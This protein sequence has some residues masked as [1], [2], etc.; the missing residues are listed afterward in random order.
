[1][2]FKILYHEEDHVL[3]T[4][5][6]QQDYED[7]LANFLSYGSQLS[8]LEKEHFWIETKTMKI[9]EVVETIETEFYLIVY[10]DH[11]QKQWYFYG[12]SMNHRD[13]FA[14][15][16][17]RNGCRIFSLFCGNTLK[18]HENANGDLINEQGEQIAR[19]ATPESE[20]SSNGS[21]DTLLLFDESESDYQ[22]SDSGVDSGVDENNNDEPDL[23]CHEEYE[24]IPEAIPAFVPD[25]ICAVDRNHNYL[26][27]WEN[28][29]LINREKQCCSTD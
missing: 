3:E 4:Y 15:C 20:I 17:L 5:F 21:D 8:S 10:D 11:C 29:E 12:D 26:G 28:E 6:T 16:E 2:K 13:H 14:L 23:H 24:E 25:F 9:H 1:M 22:N 27:T 18:L 7:M 19:P